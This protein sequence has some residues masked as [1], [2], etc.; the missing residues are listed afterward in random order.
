MKNILVIIYIIFFNSGYAQN[1]KISVEIKSTVTSRYEFV[2]DEYDSLIKFDT[3][4]I[5]PIGLNDE[6]NI[7]INNKFAHWIINGSIDSVM[8]NYENY[9]GIVTGS[10]IKEVINLNINKNIFEYENRLKIGEVYEFLNNYNYSKT[11]EFSIYKDLNVIR[12]NNEFNYEG[13]TFK[14]ENRCV[15]LNR[16]LSMEDIELWNKYLFIILD[17]NDYKLSNYVI[18]VEYIDYSGSKRNLILKG[19]TFIILPFDD[20]FVLD[21]RFQK[22]LVNIL[23]A[24]SNSFINSL[25]GDAFIDF[26]CFIISKNCN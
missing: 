16:C 3:L 20:N 4:C 5:Y 8:I 15:R 2:I 17:Q 26:L 19:N 10:F 24:F 9:K 25:N 21:Y 14:C 7:E 11:D 13:T 22:L 23:P 1:I 6:N 18:T 12:Q